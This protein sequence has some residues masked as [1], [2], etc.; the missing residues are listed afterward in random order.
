MGHPADRM[1]HVDLRLEPKAA[2]HPAILLLPAGAAEPAEFFPGYGRKMVLSVRMASALFL[3]RGNRLL[4]GEKAHLCETPDRHLHGDVTDPYPEFGLCSVQPVLLRALVLYAGA[5]ALHRHRRRSVGAQ[6]SGNA[7][8]P[9]LELALC[10]F[11]HPLFYSGDRL[12][13][14]QGEGRD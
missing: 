5:D 14:L 8:F 2:R 1:E 7:V 12:F 13:P 3:H 6:C 9:C 11:H 10:R 4:P